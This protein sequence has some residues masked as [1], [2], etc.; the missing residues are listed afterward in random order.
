MLPTSLL[1]KCLIKKKQTKTRKVIRRN[2]VE[3]GVYE[4]ENN[5]SLKVIIVNR[6]TNGAFLDNQL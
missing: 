6:K 4:V 3:L 5:I 1:S 2:L